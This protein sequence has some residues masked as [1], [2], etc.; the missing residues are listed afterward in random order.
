MKNNL[1]CRGQ[2]AIDYIVG[3]LTLA[4][5]CI[6]FL[7]FIGYFQEK[8]IDHVS[9]SL[10]SGLNNEYCNDFNTDLVNYSWNAGDGYSNDGTPICTVDN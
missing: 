6:A 4:L 9:S 10:E 8:N 1:N 3:A 2:V 5:I 7:Y